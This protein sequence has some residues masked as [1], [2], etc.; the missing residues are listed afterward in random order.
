MARSKRTN[1]S[2]LCR[3]CYGSEGKEQLLQPCNCSGT[4]GL[5]HRTCLER[6]LSQSNSTRCEICQYDFS[7]K[8][9]K[10]PKSFSQVKKKKNIIF[11]F[12]AKV[13]IFLKLFNYFYSSG[14]LDL[15]P[16]RII[17]IYLTTLFVF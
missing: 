15:Y 12:L 11:L 8:I 14:Y 17:K 3:I 10:V 2:I 16:R 7:S 4:M 5:M 1:S 6:W 13:N 9:Q